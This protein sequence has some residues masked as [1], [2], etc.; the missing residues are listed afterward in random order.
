MSDNTLSQAPPD[1]MA[2]A[3]AQSAARK[4]G[5]EQPFNAPAERP[6]TEAKRVGSVR[7]PHF[8]ESRTRE[9]FRV[10]KRHL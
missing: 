1:L 3:E 10:I 8:D 4:A 9:E 2:G 5:E 6:G 7:T